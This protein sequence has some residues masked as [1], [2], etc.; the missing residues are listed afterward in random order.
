MVLLSS[1][2]RDLRDLCRDLSDKNIPLDQGVD[3][4]FLKWLEL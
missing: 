1:D 3:P 4:E 2:L